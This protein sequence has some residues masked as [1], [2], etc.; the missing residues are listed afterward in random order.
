MEFHCAD[1]SPKDAYALLISAVV[2]RP[3]AFVTT[4]DGD[5][6]VNLAPFSFFSGVA[7]RPPLLSLS[8]GQRRWQGEARPK[9]TLAN[10][11]STRECVVHIPSEDLAAQVNASAAEL[12]PGV[13]ELDHCRLTPVP[14]LRVRPPRVAE[15]PIAME[16]VLDQIVWVGRPAVQ[17]LALVEVVCFHVD[18]AVW[19]DELRAVDTLR[20]RPLSRLGG[21]LYGRT[22]DPIA[23]DRPDWAATGFAARVTKAT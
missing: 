19:S 7:S 20:L 16:C 2:P 8:I 13:S 1:L 17:A 23:L 4:V 22:R 14:S 9:D 10:L 11:Q 12:P 15:C 3:I 5:G 18:D 6:A 21:T